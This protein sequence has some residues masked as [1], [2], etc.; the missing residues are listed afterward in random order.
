M[1]TLKNRIRI[2]KILRKTK[3]KM[4]EGVCVN[5]TILLSTDIGRW[6]RGSPTI[7]ATSEVTGEESLGYGGIMMNNLACFEYEEI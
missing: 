4:F 3:A 5:D 6:H 2:T 1:I 7:R